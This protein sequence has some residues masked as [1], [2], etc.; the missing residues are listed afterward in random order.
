MGDTTGD[1]LPRS[2]LCSLRATLAPVTAMR[3]GFLS[4]TDQG[5]VSIANF[6]TGVVIA[7]A[8]SK[9][10]LGLY[11]LGFSLVMLVQD[12]QTSL[13]LTPYM[14]YAPRLKGRAH[15][16]YTGSTLG[17]QLALGVIVAVGVMCGAF[18]CNYRFDRSLGPVLWALA[19]VIALIMLREFARRICFA[20][21]Q[22]RTAFILDVFVSAGQVGGV[23]L[24][25]RFHMLSAA[26]AY[27]VIG[28]VCGIAVLVWFLSNSDLSFPRLS[29]SVAD[30]KRNWS[31]G[32]W[33]FASGLLWTIGRN[34]YPW[35]LAAFHGVAITGVFAACIGVVSVGNPL[36]LGLQNVVGPKISHAY[37]TDGPSAVRRLVLKISAV[38]ILPVSIYSL[39]LIL[40]G[41][42]I[43]VLLYGH[44]YA[45]NNLVVAILALNILVST[46]TYSF[47]RALFAI[48]RADLDFL[49]NVLG[50]VIMVTLGLWFVLRFG[51]LGAAL[52]MLTASAITAA[53][54]A[55]A[56]LGFQ[57]FLLNEQE[58]G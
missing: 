6:V 25:A 4:L 23:L 49:L 3:Q 45:G 2:W 18:A 36:I 19:L 5:V 20:C 43:M 8:C 31:L 37:A 1:S 16:I 35:L 28:A 56:F 51:P 57:K 17:H 42:R 53:I 38:I 58:V 11:M 34:A 21:L 12:V 39:I 7:R 13:I 54:R 27:W 46:M 29:D 22:V 47:S 30:F 55:A 32:K 52:G 44:Q 41:G 48:E 33:I 40:A 14:I 9:A 24:L 50:L 10:E 26:S 15:S